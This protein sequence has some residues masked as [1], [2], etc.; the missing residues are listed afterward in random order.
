MD[1]YDKCCKSSEKAT[2]SLTKLVYKYV[3]HKDSARWAEIGFSVGEG[4]DCKLVGCLF[5]GV[6]KVYSIDDWEFLGDLSREVLRLCEI[7]QGVNNV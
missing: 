4:S 7:S 2:A 6:Q 3:W 5:Q 1:K